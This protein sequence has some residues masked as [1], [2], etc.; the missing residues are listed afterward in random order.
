MV[1]IGTGIAI[2]YSEE[3]TYGTAAG[4]VS[5]Y[6][7][8]RGGMETLQGEVDHIIPE[9]LSFRGNDSSQ[10]VAG[11]KRVTGN[12]THDL[13]FGGGWV[14]FMSHLVGHKAS[15]T[16]SSAPYTHS[17]ELGR[18]LSAG[19][20]QPQTRGITVVVDREG[21]NAA[22]STKAWLYKGLKPTSCDITF[23]QGAIANASWEFVGSDAA[24]VAIPTPTL[25]TEK[26]VTNPSAGSGT[27]IKSIK[28]GTDGSE[29]GYNV[30][31]MSIH[32]EQP[33]AERR[34]LEDATQ[35]VPTAGGHFIASGS[36]EIE[37]PDMGSSGTFDAFTDAYRAITMN[38]LIMTVEGAQATSANRKLSFDF[39]KVRITNVGEPQ[40][41]DA[42]LILKTV[43][44]EAA[45]SGTASTGMGTMTLVNSEAAAYT[46]A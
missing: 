4:S 11:M 15:T 14:M 12:I 37:A 42:G 24:T 32:L 13:R 20:T 8:P 5:H 46:A 39:P 27:L 38:S 33:L 45:Y 41:S 40:V 21:D 35:L 1:K 25:P 29:T 3:S 10:F 7:D 6:L 30:R 34:T 17:L 16:G 43:E 31:S 22:S 26:Y 28:Y 44:W 36:F 19:T 2:G 9:S 23:E 18:D